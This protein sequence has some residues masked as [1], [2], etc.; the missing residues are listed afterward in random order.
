MEHLAESLLWRIESER[1]LA[2]RTPEFRE[3]PSASLF[4]KQARLP[5]GKN[6][7]G[8]KGITFVRH[9]SN[10]NILVKVEG[11]ERMDIYTDWFG[12]KKRSVLLRDA[13]WHRETGIIG[14]V[15]VSGADGQG[16]TKSQTIFRF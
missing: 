8:G 15:D 11:N 1:K 4:W 2:G 7:V 10:E 5:C 13:D 6:S 12:W 14:G 3:G 9:D 16:Q